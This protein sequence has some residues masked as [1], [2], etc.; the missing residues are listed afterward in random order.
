[1]SDTTD[2]SPIVIIESKFCDFN[3]ISEGDWRKNKSAVSGILGIGKPG[4]EIKFNP[5]AQT[6]MIKCLERI[7]D[8]EKQVMSKVEVAKLASESGG[9]VRCAIHNIQFYCGVGNTEKRISPNKKKFVGNSKKSEVDSN[10]VFCSRGFPLGLFHSLGKVLYGKRE[11][12]ELEHSP[13][14]NQKRGKLSFNPETVIESSG[15]DQSTFTLFLHQ[16][17]PQFFSDIDELMLASDYMSCSDLLFSPWQL[18]IKSALHV[19]AGS[20]ASRGV[21][22]S[23]QNPSKT[24]SSSFSALKQLKKPMWFESFKKEINN[25]E[26]LDNCIVGCIQ[27]GES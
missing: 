4:K 6:L 17:Y 25:R 11:E 10:K 26:V 24:P 18:E 5:I 16:N 7:L 2:G 22:F 1:M 14:I 12:S 8:S 27:R 19:Y 15:S 21:L 3:D 9:D 23:N 13:N 20:V